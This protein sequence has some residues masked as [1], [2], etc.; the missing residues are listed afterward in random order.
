MLNSH[1]SRAT[2]DAEAI[3]ERPGL[4]GDVQRSPAGELT[5]LL[6][7][8]RRGS[9][10]AGAELL[11]TVYDDLRRLAGRELS[12]ERA[13]TLQATEV[14]HEI[15]LRLAASPR[16]PRWAD[17]GHFF[18]IVSRLARQV[19]VDLARE[20]KA[21]KRGGGMTVSSLSSGDEDCGLDPDP[22][23]DQVALHRA[24]DELR[25]LDGQAVQIVELRYYLGLTVNETARVLGLGRATVDRKW[26]AARAWL[27]GALC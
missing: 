10:E 11:R 26:R 21:R 17:R 4:P 3:P 19:L 25:A 5:E 16:Q 18:A 24:L 12:L 23:V 22:T 6:L 15:Y 9:R 14:V 1:P 13:S 20:K 8:W 27:F 7:A 2:D